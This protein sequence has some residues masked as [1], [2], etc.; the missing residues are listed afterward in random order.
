MFLKSVLVIGGAGYI[1]TELSKHLNDKGYDLTVLDTFWFG[2]HIHSASS[3]KKIEMDIRDLDKS[4]DIGIFDVVIHLAD[5][6]ND[7]SVEI[8]PSLAWEIGCLGTRNVLEWAINNGVKKFIAASSGSVYGVSPEPKVCE[9]TALNPISTYN[10]VKMVKE[11]IIQSYE[12]QISTVILRPATVAG[13]SARQRLDLAVNVLTYEALKNSIIRV[14]GGSQVRPHVHL[15]DMIRAYLFFIEKDL[16]GIYN[17]GF[18]NLTMHEL[19]ER[20]KRITG[21]RIQIENSIDPRSYR[22]CSHK[23]LDEGFKPEKSLDDAI[24]EIVSHFNSKDLQEGDQTQ[25]LAWMKKVLNL[26]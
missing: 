4:S 17:V 9:D 18:E 15:H 24:L 10:K 13:V 12:K 6:A 21:A 5:V 11:R 3:I 20:I 14:F 26:K 16:K 22:L 25:N 23:L 8:D 1:G 19:A 2:D 7:P